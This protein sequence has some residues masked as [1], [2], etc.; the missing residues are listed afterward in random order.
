MLLFVR[1]L[2]HTVVYFHIR[3]ERDKYVSWD[4]SC[5]SYFM[6]STFP[7]SPGS[8]ACVLQ[9]AKTFLFLLLLGCSTEQASM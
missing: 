2:S 9:V 6:D 5:L 1:Y 3:E 8:Q 4:R 7:A